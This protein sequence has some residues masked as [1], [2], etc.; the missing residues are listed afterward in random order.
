MQCSPKSAFGLFG[1]LYFVGVVLSSLTLQPLADKIG[2]RPIIIF[3]VGLQ[4]ICCLILLYSKSR[5]LTYGIVFIM[6]IAM[7]PKIISYV[8]VMEIFPK[9][10]HAFTSA[11]FFTFDGLVIS[12]C[13]L[14]FMYIDNN[15]RS[16]YTIVTIT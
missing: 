2:R 3:G 14:Y 6:G 11:L 12:W 10:S 7:P 16:L 1:M 4:T 13:S 5:T 15:W 9:S 8:L